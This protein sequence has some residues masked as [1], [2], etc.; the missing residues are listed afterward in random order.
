MVPN[1]QQHVVPRHRRAGTFMSYFLPGTGWQVRRSGRRESRF[2]R[3]AAF[4]RTSARWQRGSV[5]NSTVTVAFAIVALVSVVLLG[6]LYLSQVFGTASQGTDIQELEQE[7]VELR[8]RQRA[9]ELEG[10]ELRSIQAVEDHIQ[11]LNLVVADQVAYLP[12][13]SDRVAFDANN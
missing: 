9:L 7:V 2:A 12:A 10:A 8:E 13:V 6:F 4:G 5:N 11:E 3:L 1:V